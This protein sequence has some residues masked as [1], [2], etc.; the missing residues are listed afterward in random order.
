MSE[1]FAPSVE[2]IVGERPPI[3]PLRGDPVIVESS[4]RSAFVPLLILALSLLGW[5][6][7]QA[8][9]VQADRDVIQ[10]AVAGQN[11]QI[12]E[13]K[14][15]RT[16]FETLYRGTQ[17]LA[18]GGNANARLVVDE[19]KKRGLAITGTPPAAPKK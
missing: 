8:M 18:D 2:E 11:R 5:F 12:E 13:S 7:F 19:L 6:V 17:Q 9:Q 10:T 3:G 1:P 16:A 14:K 15:L 4:Q